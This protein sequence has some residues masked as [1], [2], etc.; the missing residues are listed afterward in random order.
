MLA[1]FQ[2][3]KHMLHLHVS[4]LNVFISEVMDRMKSCFDKGTKGTK[5]IWVRVRIQKRSCYIELH[6][7]KTD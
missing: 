6:Q 2:Q 4:Y 1:L 5:T 3:S 7:D